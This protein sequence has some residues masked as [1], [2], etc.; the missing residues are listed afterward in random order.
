MKTSLIE[1]GVAYHDGKLGV[2]EVLAISGSVAEPVV[3]YRIL[4]A[5]AERE[6]VPLSGMRP[7]AGTE[8]AC[9]LDSFAKWAKCAV[10]KDQ[11]PVLLADLKASRTKLPPGEKALMESLARQ[12]DQDFPLKAGAGL[13]LTASEQRA[14]RGLQKK[15]LGDAGFDGT[16]GGEIVLTQLG[17]SWIRMHRKA[18]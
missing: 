17:V 10:A 5:K 3:R 11:V 14:A 4:A 18:I 9:A 6:Y 1:Q 12:F 8:S 15:G 16:G 13:S 7:V 2:R